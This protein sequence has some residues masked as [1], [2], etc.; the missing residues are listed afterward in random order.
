[1]YLAKIMPRFI[2]MFSSPCSLP[3]QSQPLLSVCQWGEVA[4]PTDCLAVRPDRDYSSVPGVAAFLPTYSMIGGINAPKKMSCQGTDGRV[5]AQMIKNRDDLR[6]DAV[7]QQV[8]GLMNQLL[9]QDEEAA[10]QKLS[11]RTY[12]VVPLSQRS[13]ILEWCSDTQP[14]AQYL[15]GEGGKTGAH[16]RYFPRQLD[17][18]SC[19]KRMSDLK[20]KKPPASLQ[21]REKV[22]L[23]VC[24]D[25]SPVMKY[26]FLERFPSAGSHYLARTAYTKS[27]ASNSMVGHI[28]GLGDRHTNN[29]LV[30]TRTGELIHIDLGVAFEQ[31]KILPTPEK[32]PFRLSRDIVDGFGPA[33]VEGVFRKNCERSLRVLREHK[34][35]TT[36]VSA[37]H[38]L[39]T[40]PVVHT[41]HTPHTFPVDVLPGPTLLPRTET[42]S[43]SS[44]V[45]QI[46]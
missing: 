16:K 13:G 2:F 29:I 12:K 34:V 35:D 31:G 4:V 41:L 26:F 8:F 37:V 18:Q 11:I 42:L 6:Q 38:T 7:M 10:Q 43:S 44:P 33:G 46:E 20:T 27:A 32:I 24:A 40:H 39:H 28:L 3:P 19:R 17:S 25:F 45:G 9:A 14:L 22:F 36:L 21:E 30:D 23:E 5:R 1:M 15:V